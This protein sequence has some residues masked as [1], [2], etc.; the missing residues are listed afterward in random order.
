MAVFMEKENKDQKNKNTSEGWHVVVG[1]GNP[2]KQYAHHRHNIGFAVL[3]AFAKHA[4]I[5]LNK[6][7]HKGIV[8][9]GEWQQKKIVLLKPQ[10]YM[11]ESGQS[12]VGLLQFYKVPLSQF[13]V[14]Y[15]E[16]DL[17]FG[18]VR[19]RKSGGAGG[20]NGIR[21]IIQKVDGQDFSRLRIGIGRPPGQMLA[22]DFVLQNFSKQDNEELPFMLQHAVQGLEKWLM[23]SIDNAMNWT[24]GMQDK[25]K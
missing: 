13:I 6:F 11:N 21:S 14:V 3:D 2:G 8:G 17:P 1:L 25:G 10:T 23:L 24:N 7:M 16:L 19:M 20:H 22:K 15:D 9:I 5:E 4:N 18:D 12:V